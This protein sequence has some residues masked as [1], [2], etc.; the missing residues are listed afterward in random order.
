MMNPN[1]LREDVKPQAF[2]VPAASLSRPSHEGAEIAVQRS[3]AVSRNGPQRLAP[4]L[5]CISHNNLYEGRDPCLISDSLTCGFVAGL[6]EFKVSDLAKPLAALERQGLVM[7]VEAG[8]LRL[9]DVR[10][11]ESL[12]DAH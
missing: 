12:V 8:G 5:A 11:L 6:L 2:R 4:L 7:P 10:A 1:S 9:T 3:R